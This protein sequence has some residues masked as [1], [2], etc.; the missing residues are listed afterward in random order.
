[1][2]EEKIKNLDELSGIISNL[3][4]QN[5]KIVHCHGVFDVVH[6]GHI[7]HFLASKK[8]GDIL[9]VTTTPDQFIQKGPGRP[10]F[11]QDIRLKHLAA[12]ECIDFVALNKWPTA[13]DTIKLIKPDFYCKGKEVLDNKD[14]DAIKGSE[15]T[16]S[17]LALEEEALKFVGGKLHLTDEITFSASKIINQINYSIP[18]ETKIYLNKFRQ[19][20]PIEKI[21]DVLESIKDVK[22]LIIGDAILD[23]YVFCKSMEKAGKEAIIP[24][25]FTN[26]ET[27]L[28]GVF[29][30]ANSIAG[31]TKE[32]GILTQIGNDVKEL[33]NKGLME[34]VEKNI[35]VSDSETLIKKRYLND[36]NNHKI[37]EI[38]NK[39][40]IILDYDMQER[41]LS[42]LDKNI[43][44]YNLIIVSDFGHGMLFPSLIEYLYNHGKFL[45]VNTQLNSGNSGYNFITKYKKADFVS[46]SERELRLP[47]QEKSTDIRIPIAKLSSIMNLNKVNITLGKNGS[48]YYQDGE[49]YHSPAFITETIDTVGAGD[50][51]FSLTALL[52]YKKINPTLIPFIGNC[53]GGLSTR[54]IGNKK[55][56]DPMELRKFISY[57]MK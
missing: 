44:K 9:V 2:G 43:E 54:V 55:Q 6:Y 57:I 3:K 24:H 39:N 18:E 53:I 34:N 28:G 7:Q 29:N 32:L 10:F 14:I 19:D 26:S 22:P 1:M 36:Y 49:F 42:Y 46:L 4:A 17:N 51:N 23:E 47:L 38:Y 8:L 11:H 35:F 40:E 20:F 21:L 13:V 48:I 15:K 45:A 27:Y 16:V 31:F 25:K 37:F 33:V 12:L 50:A 5:K 41:V 52:A 30:V 56:I